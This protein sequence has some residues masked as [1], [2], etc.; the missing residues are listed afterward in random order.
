VARKSETA[1]V[2]FLFIKKLNAAPEI[3]PRILE[4]LMGTKDNKKR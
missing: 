2:N 1:N 3:K 4:I